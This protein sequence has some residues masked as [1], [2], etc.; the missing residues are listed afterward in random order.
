MN[1]RKNFITP[2]NNLN[3]WLNSRQSISD[4]LNKIGNYRVEVINSKQNK[5]LLSEK[6][7]FSTYQKEELYLREVL[8]YLNEKPLMYART[9]LPKIYLRGFWGNIKK[10]KEKPLANI[11]FENK[12]IKRSKFDFFV[13]QKRDNLLK[14]INALNKHNL[15]VVVTRQS[16][17]EMRKQCVL[18]TEVFFSNFNDVNY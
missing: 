6:I 8:I 2:S 12:S 1:Y 5:L 7:Q 18:L 3:T 9:L 4:K 13:P 11:V 17:F 15:K 14:I 16:S 10:L